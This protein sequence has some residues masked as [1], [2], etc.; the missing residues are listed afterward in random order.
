MYCK[1]MKLQNVRELTL[2]AKFLI[3]DCLKFEGNVVYF[4][5]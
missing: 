2:E 1:K 5:L 3:Y 4:T